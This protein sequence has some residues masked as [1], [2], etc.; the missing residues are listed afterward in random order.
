MTPTDILEL[1]RAAASLG[2]LLL[3]LGYR[4]DTRRGAQAVADRIE[5]SHRALLTSASGARLL[6]ALVIDEGLL[7]DLMQQVARVQVEY[8]RAL[9]AAATPEER[10]RADRWAEREVCE[11]LH[12]IRIR[13]GGELPLGELQDVWRS[14][15][16]AEAYA[17]TPRALAE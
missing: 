2:S 3:N 17:A 15:G 16:C 12:R 13:N 14:Y 9:R 1:L 8:R 6:D 11:H 5:P 4:A 7:G 10:R